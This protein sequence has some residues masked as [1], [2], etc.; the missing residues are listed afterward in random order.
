MSVNIILICVVLLIIQRSVV[1]LKCYKCSGGTP[2][3]GPLFNAKDAGVTIVEDVGNIVCLKMVHLSNDRFMERR[4]DTTS[5]TTSISSPSAT[6]DGSV[7]YCCST[8]LCNGA[9]I[10]LASIMLGLS[11]ATLILFLTK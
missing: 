7:N 4:G 8:D 9:Q 3:C 10:K 11:L 2:G 1:S 6:T 5:C